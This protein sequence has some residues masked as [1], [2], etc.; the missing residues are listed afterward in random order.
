MA[1]LPWGKVDV[2]TNEL[3]PKEA[4]QMSREV[5]Y[6]GMDVH[7]EA[8]VIAVQNTRGHLVM[9]SVVETKSSSILQFIHGLQGELHVTWEEGTWAAWLYDLLQPHVHQVLVCTPRRNA[10]LKEGS[11]NDKVDAGKLADLLRTGMLRPV[12]H[13]EHGLRTLRELARTYQT[14]SQD[15]NRVMNR[16]K[17][18]YRGWGI[19]CGGTQVYAPRY[20]EEW[21][22][23]I[24][25]VGV[26]RRAEL[27]YQQLDGLQGLRRTLRPELLPESRKH[28][29]ANLLR[30]IPCIG[31][32]RAARL[33]ALM[34]TPHRFRSKRQLWTYS[35][36]GIE[37]HDSAQYRYVGGQVQRSKKPQQ[38]RGLNQNHNH[39][40]K[41]IYKS[42]ATR[43]SC[44]TGPFHDFYEALL[45]RGM[46]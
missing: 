36:L 28:K 1:V 5:K 35:G 25:H 20:R 27:L 31:P 2:G 6:I 45:A 11:K 7:K 42:T 10:L 39:E 23:K 46:T 13:G 43:A 16:L 30:Q 40:M 17:V 44:T 18:L 19:A 15:L 8:I 33:I 32:I 34:Q 24:K 22:G 14:L 26:R 4:T 41:E 38:L 29:A 12:Y 9:E 3:P 21:L 37:T